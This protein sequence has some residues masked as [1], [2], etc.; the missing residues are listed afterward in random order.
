MKQIKKKHF[1]KLAAILALTF[2]LTWFFY[3][4]EKLPR[5]I[6][7]ATALIETPVA[8]AS[9]LSYYFNLA[10]PVYDTPWAILLINLVFSIVVVVLVEKILTRRKS[11]RTK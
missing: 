3:A 9:G 6:R 8:I 10:I 5:A 7:A 4:H 1:S 11:K 2:F